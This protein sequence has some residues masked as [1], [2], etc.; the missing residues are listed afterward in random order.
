MLAQATL[1]L[2]RCQD[3][4]RREMVRILDRMR[5][6]GS[7]MPNEKPARD[8]AT[9]ASGSSPVPR[10]Q[11]R[12]MPD[13]VSAMDREALLAFCQKTAR[14]SLAATDG[15]MAAAKGCIHCQQR[16]ALRAEK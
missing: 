12:A 9:T 13:K 2:I 6:D 10:V 11:S 7:L 3:H 1:S 14:R 15:K 8:E 5:K 4:L 16:I